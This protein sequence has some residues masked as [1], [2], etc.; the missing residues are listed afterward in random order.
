MIEFLRRADLFD[1]P[2]PQQRD[3]IG[4]FESFF[5]IVRDEDRGKPVRS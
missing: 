3:A 2:I 1:A 5:L 4:Q